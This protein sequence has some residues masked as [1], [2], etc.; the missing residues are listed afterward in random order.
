V[1]VLANVSFRG[2][3]GGMDVNGSTRKASTFVAFCL[4]EADKQVK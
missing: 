1:G 3:V 2:R 4:Q